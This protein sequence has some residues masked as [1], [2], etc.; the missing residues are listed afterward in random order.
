MQRNHTLPEKETRDA[1]VQS[2][3]WQFVENDVTELNTYISNSN[4][5]KRIQIL[6]GKSMDDKVAENLDKL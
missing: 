3:E 4:V 1:I 2:E 6:V 5:D